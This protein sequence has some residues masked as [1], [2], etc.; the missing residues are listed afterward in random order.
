MELD[1]DDDE[2]DDNEGGKKDVNAIT[3]RN[4]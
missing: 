2:Y 4:A 3:S 1:N